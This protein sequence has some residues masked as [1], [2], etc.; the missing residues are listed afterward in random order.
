MITHQY[1]KVKWKDENFGRSSKTNTPNYSILLNYSTY[2]NMRNLLSISI[3]ESE[4]VMQE[5]LLLKKFN[6]KF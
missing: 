4:N 6:I 2:M 1:F 5:L 3:C